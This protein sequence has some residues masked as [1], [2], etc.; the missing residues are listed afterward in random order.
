MNIIFTMNIKLFFAIR[1]YYNKLFMIYVAVKI[2]IP[3]K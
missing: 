2:L 3:K 1:H